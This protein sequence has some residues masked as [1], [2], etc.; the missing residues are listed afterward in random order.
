MRHV[1]RYV[2]PDDPDAGAGAPDVVLGP[3]DSHHLA[4]VV[5]RRAGDAVEVI[6]PSG[7]IWP[8]E[9]ADLGPPARLR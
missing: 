3:D 7:G 9:V 8:C 1:F 5:R 2:V 6:G 4:R